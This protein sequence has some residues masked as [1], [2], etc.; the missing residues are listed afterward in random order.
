M[1]DLETNDIAYLS[2]KHKRDAAKTAILQTRQALERAAAEVDNYLEKFRDAETDTE[3][4]TAVNWCIHYI[5]GLIYMLLR[6]FL[7]HVGQ[8]NNFRTSSETYC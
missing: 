1:I 2:S 8:P 6:L 7:T 3:K 5:D 4:A